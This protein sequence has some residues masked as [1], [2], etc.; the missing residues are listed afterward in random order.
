MAQTEQI[1]S[2]RDQI[3]S[4]RALLDK[5][6]Q[7]FAMALP[8]HIKADQFLRVAISTIQKNPDLLKCT[9][10]SVLSCL[11]ES[12]Q[13]GLQVNGS[14][15]EA[16]LVPFN[17]K[18]KDG[19]WKKECQLIIGYK[20]YMKL[21]RNSGEVSTIKA[22]VVYKG[23]E[24]KVEDGLDPVLRHVRS[25]DPPELDKD[26]PLENA[27]RGAYAIVKMKDGTPQFVFLWKW[28]IDRARARSKQK[29]GLMWTTDYP[30][31]AKK[32]A[33]RRLAKYMPQSPEIQRAAALEDAADLGISQD[34]ESAIEIS[35]T[36]QE[37][38]QI[39]N[40]TKLDALVDAD[41]SKQ[42]EKAP[43]KPQAAP[44]STPKQ[45]Q[46]GR[47][48]QPAASQTAAGNPDYATGADPDP[49]SGE[50]PL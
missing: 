41:K 30:E 16:Y 6:K 22:E 13:L 2:T 25:E 31:G 18:Q 29:D 12:A 20:G 45:S 26:E 46:G 32:T 47:K 40:G 23:D 48:N 7:Q 33:I 28:E 44:T 9:Q 34:I 15:G 27:V 49:F 37:P 17:N 10:V 5:S 1:V 14:L 11:M 50:L 35:A 39:T 19:T 4:M 8:R 24:L 21:A 42:E 36:E 3:N 38:A 43:E